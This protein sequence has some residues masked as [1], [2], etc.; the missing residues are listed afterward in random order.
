MPLPGIEAS[1]LGTRKC[2][3]GCTDLCCIQDAPA[4]GP[5]LLAASAPYPALSN[6]VLWLPLVI[7]AEVRSVPVAADDMAGFMNRVTI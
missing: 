1:R 4:L 5:W 6:F 7:L 2:Q 3:D